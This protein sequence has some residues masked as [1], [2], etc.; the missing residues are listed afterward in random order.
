M[1]NNKNGFRYIVKYLISLCLQLAYNSLTVEGALALVNMLMN[2]PK[3]ALEEINICVSVNTS[4]ATECIPLY[5]LNILLLFSFEQNVLVNE[6]FVNLLEITCQ[7]HPGL[8][9]QYEGVGGFMAKKP[10]KRVDP[11]K[12]IQVCTV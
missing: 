12:I 11:M 1:T 6:N 10:P 8:N 9:V 7:E 3:T 4:T 2:T 5:M